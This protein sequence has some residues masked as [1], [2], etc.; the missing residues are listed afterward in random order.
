MNQGRGYLFKVHLSLKKT[1]QGS[2]WSV[3]HLPLSKEVKSPANGFSV[4]TKKHISCFRVSAFDSIIKWNPVFFH[5]S[6]HRSFGNR[7]GENAHHSER[8]GGRSWHHQTL[9][10]NQRDSGSGDHHRPR[11]L[12]HQHQGKRW[13]VPQLCKSSLY[14][15][16]NINT[17]SH[18]L[19]LNAKLMQNIHIDFFF[20]ILRKYTWISIKEILGFVL[21][22]N[23]LIP[24]ISDHLIR[25][26][27]LYMI[28]VKT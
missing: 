16:Q 26:L 14:G 17:Q 9:A 21:I 25:L 13:P 20:C 19:F 8:S 2:L 23:E 1:L 18:S 3:S 5:Q 4:L 28:T 24:F 22:W 15:R 11:Q 10:H 12:H 7:K 6:Y 27:H